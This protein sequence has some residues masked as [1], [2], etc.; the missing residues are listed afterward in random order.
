MNKMKFIALLV[1][2][3]LIP[4]VFASGWGYY[5][6]KLTADVGVGAGKVYASTDGTLDKSKLGANSSA[7]SR[8]WGWSK[9]K[10]FNQLYVFAQADEGYRFVGWKEDTSKNYADYGLRYQRAIDS[11]STEQNKPTTVACHA[12]FEPIMTKDVYLCV[13]D[14]LRLYYDV[15]GSSGATYSYDTDLPD[16]VT[17]SSEAQGGGKGCVLTVTARREGE[18]VLTLKRQT[19]NDGALWGDYDIIRIVVGT[20]RTVKR[21]HSVELAPSCSA[22]GTGAASWN[23]SVSEPGLVTVGPQSGANASGTRFSVT[24]REA[25]KLTVT[26]GNVT[27]AS[28]K[29]G[30][31]YVYALEVLDTPTIPVTISPGA[32]LRVTATYDEDARSFS[33]D[34]TSADGI[35]VALSGSGSRSREVEISVAAN[36]AVGSSAKFTVVADGEMFLAYSI[37]V[38]DVLSATEGAGFA[39]LVP[40]AAET[41]VTGSDDPAIARIVATGTGLGHSVRVDALSLGDATCWATNA[42]ASLGYAAYRVQVRGANT[43]S[44]SLVAFDVGEKDSQVLRCGL[45]G[46]K[47]TTWTA[48][49]DNPSVASVSLNTTSAS[50]QVEATITG[51]SVGQT[52][53][54]VSSDYYTETINVRVV[55]GL[56][57]NVE[58]PVGETHVFE[59]AAFGA[60]SMNEVPSSDAHVATAKLESGKLKITGIAEGSSEIEVEQ[61]DFTALY[62]VRVY[63]SEIEK[64]VQLAYSLT[65]TGANSSHMDTYDAIDGVTEIVNA[66]VVSVVATGGTVT[67]TAAKAGTA[68]VDVRC[69]MDGLTSFVTVHYTVT[70]TDVGNRGVW[71]YG[72]GYVLYEDVTDIRNLGDDVLIAFG[73]PEKVGRFEIPEGL[74]ATAEILAV[75]GGGA[76]GGRE[77]DFGRGGGGG[78][79]GGYVAAN[80]K[81]FVEGSYAVTVGAGGANP[82]H[83]A[84]AQGA[85]GGESRITNAQGGVMI[86]AQGGGGGGTGDVSGGA[87]APGGSGGGGT[88]AASGDG[89]VAGPGGRGAEGQG[90]TGGMPSDAIYNSGAGGGGAGTVGG[91]DGA[92]GAGKNSAITGVATLYAAGGAG[93]VSDRNA[94]GQPGQGVGFGGQGG[95]GMPGGA[96]ADGAVYVRLTALRRVVKVPVPTTNDLLTLSFEWK[97]G[98]ACYPIDYAGKTFRSPSDARTYVWSD[99]IAYATA[100]E[101]ICSQEGGKHVGVGSYTLVIHLKDGFAWDTDGDPNSSGSMEDRHFRWYV[102][103]PGESGTE[104]AALDANKYVSW[105]SEADATITITAKSVPRKKDGVAQSYDLA[106]ADKV[107]GSDAGLNLRAVSVSTSADGVAWGDPVLVWTADGSAMRLTAGTAALAVDAATSA[108]A[109][110]ETGLSQARWTRLEIL[111]RDNGI[112]RTNIGATYNEQTGLYEKNP[113]DGAAQVTMTTAGSTLVGNCEAETEVPWRY[114]AHPVEVSAVN[115]DIYVNGTP[116]NPYALYEGAEVTVYYRGKGGYELSRILVDDVPIAIVTDPDNPAYNLDHYTIPAISAPHTVVVEYARFY[117]D[118]KATPAYVTYDAQVHV[119]DVELTGWSGDYK[120]EVRYALRPDAPPEEYFTAE[121]FRANPAFA[122]MKN[123]GTYEIAYRVYAYQPG[124]GETLTQPGWA[125]VDTGRQGVGTVT[126]YPRD[127]TVEPVYSTIETKKDFKHNGW[128][129]VTPFVDG[130]DWSVINTSGWTIKTTYDNSNASTTEGQEACAPGLYPMWIE[131]ANDG[132]VNGNYRVHLRY[133]VLAV[134]KRAFLVDRIPQSGFLNPED[135]NAVTGVPRVEKVYDGVPIGLTVNVT[136]PLPTETEKYAVQYR[137]GDSGIW[138]DSCSVIHAGTYKIWYKIEQTNGGSNPKYISTTNYQYVVISPRAVTLTSASAS[139]AYDGMPLTALSVTSS[140]MLGAGDELTCQVTGEQTVVGASANTF[141]Y[142]IVGTCDPSDYVVTVVPGT[143]TVTAG[144]V[145]INGVEQS[146]NPQRPLDQGKTGVEDVV[147]YYDGLPTNLVVT[148]DVPANARVKFSLDRTDTSSWQDSLA[149]IDVGEYIVYYAIDAANYASVTNFGRVTIKPSEI[150]GGDIVDHVDAGGGRIHLAFKP[151]TTGVLTADVV[152]DL[153][154]AGRLQ[155]VYATSEAALETA[156]SVVVPLRDPSGQLDLDKG[157]IWVTIDPSVNPAR[158]LLWKIVV[159]EKK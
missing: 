22:V 107:V 72:D 30:A 91:A 82:S 130:E 145:V 18:G 11:S 42:M 113:N 120:T 2:F 105:Q 58:V 115:G 8:G 19:T 34:K 92:G 102:T 39:D 126:V 156:Q 52:V 110:S 56:V 134:T 46:R 158:P 86:T 45:A 60:V 23:T 139:K 106:L 154:A 85:A 38:V 64:S 74:V 28:V 50:D 159:T 98:L 65:Q 9:P 71:P 137:L 35:S 68:Q 20:E 148:V 109:F 118:V 27:T 12:Y 16:C 97:D 53:V 44:I 127:L 101:V 94:A 47:P 100:P 122:N 33:F 78:G 40:R 147:K 6:A 36:A 54:T 70:V 76:G 121:A 131:G 112:F 117:G 146:D 26:A 144:R 124:Y 49:S 140:D 73:N 75:G 41:W 29:S 14:Q 80:E 5:Y 57:A 37:T 125:W 93:G 103:E 99:V 149:L 108:I 135:P 89:R 142:T 31:E 77:N 79:A 15:A 157:W 119:Y 95:S 25:G 155:V 153:A 152:K 150:Q 123:I 111:V 59:N 83:G 136:D 10:T 132:A 151:Q 13:D 17:V 81:R 67:F 63:K 129:N 104:M 88:W 3:F 116:Y 87:G 51:L 84:A 143:L 128:A 21:G 1:A 114:V 141:S 61:A 138:E 43:R 69:R 4:A 48:V 62:T 90:T 7:E 66:G 96:G 55:K 32:T 24:G 133:G